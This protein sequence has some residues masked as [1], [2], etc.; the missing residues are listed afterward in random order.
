M[1]WAVKEKQFIKKHL[2]LKGSSFG[3]QFDET[4]RHGNHNETNGILIGPEISRIFAEI[5]FQSVDCRVLNDLSLPNDDEILIEGK[6][7][8]VR[9]YVD[10]VFIFANSSKIA[11]KVYEK[12][13]DELLNFNLHVNAQKTWQTPRP[14]VTKK[15][16]VIA[17]ATNT[18]NNFLARF[19]EV[20]HLEDEIHILRP[21][22]I[23]NKWALTRS[24]L[25][26]IKTVCASHEV[27][28]DEVASF[29]ISVFVD[30]LIKLAD[31]Q[32]VEEIDEEKQTEYAEVILVILEVLFF[33]YGVAPSV[34]ASYKMCTAVVLVQRFCRSYLPLHRISVAQRTFD[35]TARL[36][37][38]DVFTLTSSVQGFIALEAI[39]VALASRELG[40]A[41]L[42][43]P[44]VVSRLFISDKSPSYL[45]I[46]SALLYMGDVPDYAELREQIIEVADELLGDLS[47]IRED[48][49]RACLLLDMLSCPYI[50]GVRKI[51]WIKS[52]CSKIDKPAPKS[53]DFVAY[54]NSCHELTWFVDWRQLDLLNNLEK[55]ELKSTY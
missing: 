24:F 52:F 23:F 29:L 22:K 44:N 3:A 40:S 14:F 9:R 13:T 32:K 27:P 36:L 12:Y 42:L 46:I 10:D 7:F 31:L 43:P 1:S 30:R 8:S 34:S 53:M 37:E 15:S 28:Y 47:D 25:D 17:L 54:L 48:A 6:D 26:E 49:Q 21:K 5:I 19:V 35:L 51:K 2:P 50:E 39:N 11:K 38:S 16:M 18:A 33:L 45:Q 41:Y 4:M 20:E 55:K